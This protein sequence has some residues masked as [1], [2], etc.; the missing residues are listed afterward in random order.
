MI[1]LNKKEIDNGT[2]FENVKEELTN[3]N[4]S[5]IHIDASHAKY[6]LKIYDAIKSAI[7][8]VGTYD[9]SDR[10][11]IYTGCDTVEMAITFSEYLKTLGIESKLILDLR[12]GT[13]NCSLLMKLLKTSEDQKALANSMMETAKWLVSGKKKGTYIKILSPRY[14]NPSPDEHKLLLKYDNI[15]NE[16]AIF[17]GNKVNSRD[18]LSR[19]I[20][21]FP[22]IR[23][24]QK[25]G[26]DFEFF[27]KVYYEAMS[28]H[29]DM[30]I[31]KIRGLK[32]YEHLL[33]SSIEGKSLRITDEFGTNLTLS[34]NKRPLLAE[35]GRAGNMSLDNT[36]PF[37]IWTTNHY[38]G[39][40]CTAPVETSANGVIISKIPLITPYG[41]INNYKIAFKDGKAVKKTKFIDSKGR[42]RIAITKAE[43]GNDVLM[44]LIGLSNNNYTGDQQKAFQARGIIAELGVCPVN[45]VIEKHLTGLESTTGN[46]LLDEKLRLHIATGTNEFMGGKTPISFNNSRV[47]HTD[48]LL[49]ERYDI[50]PI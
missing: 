43:S 9:K 4:I 22:T 36:L 47:W 35:T 48:F 26:I 3:K 42:E 41:T 18:L 33:S 34:L 38:S 21:S 10:T 37:E 8:A 49:G 2:W 13:K 16:T 23:E 15:Y 27:K 31:D 11:V 1:I 29:P 17:Y 24:A 28:I 19:S 5:E 30:I 50:Q 20:F 32:F 12:Q 45:P 25:L 14:Y 7:S 39:E 46:V 6:S 44:E 40:L